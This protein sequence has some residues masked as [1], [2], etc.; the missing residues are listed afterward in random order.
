MF[1]LLCSSTAMSKNL[2][3]YKFFTILLGLSIQL[4]NIHHYYCGF[5]FLYSFTHRSTWVMQKGQ[6]GLAI[7]S[8]LFLKA[9][10]VF[11]LIL[12]TFLSFSWLLEHLC[13]SGTTNTVHC[14]FYNSSIS[15]TRH[16][17]FRINQWS[18]ITT[19]LLSP[20]INTGSMKIISCLL[21]C[22]PSH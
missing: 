11:V 1:Q 3:K 18:F 8:G 2:G 20:Q 19:L 21:N 4:C 6:P 12:N 16:S 13:T 9:C 5:F 10:S 7:I 15:T 22:P 17:N 14:F